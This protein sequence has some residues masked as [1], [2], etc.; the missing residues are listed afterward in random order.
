V[1][2]AVSSAVGVVLLVGVTV[3]VAAT[4]GTVAT[5]DPGGT[6]PVAHLTLS[7]DAE[8][9]RVALTH[10]G[11]ETLN[12]TALSVT[13]SVDGTSLDHQPP[14]P[15]FAATGFESGPTGP[16]NVASDDDWSAGETAGFRLASTN[17]PQLTAGTRV[18][19][20]V[21]AERGVIA[22]LET[23]AA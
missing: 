11:G 20:T 19:V 14:V 10:E 3:L 1:P 7:A 18:E 5:V 23:T 17:D 8:S 21:A 6:V 16:F 22:R 13:V 9:D 4:V 15:F 12:V 2:R